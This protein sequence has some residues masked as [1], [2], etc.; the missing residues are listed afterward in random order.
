[1]AS[2]GIIQEYVVEVKEHLQELE[3]SLLTMEREGTSKEGIGEIFR[4]AHSIK[5]AAAYMG[6]E[7][8]ANLTHGLESIIG[9]I[10]T[11]ARPVTQRG[12][13]AMLECVDVIA[14]AL[15]H[16]QETG[17][18]PPLPPGFLDAL[19]QVFESDGAKTDTRTETDPLHFLCLFAVEL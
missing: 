3:Q 6:F 4:A 13:T 10:Q 14:G 5:G 2:E 9:Q 15:G 16:L 8:M 19:Q 1:M 7:H 11:R 12:I 18:E 17:D